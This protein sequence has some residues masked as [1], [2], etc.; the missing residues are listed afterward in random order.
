MEKKIVIARE[1]GEKF[2]TL[3]TVGYEEKKTCS[4]KA[5]MSAADKSVSLETGDRCLCQF[6]IFNNFGNFYNYERL[7]EREEFSPILVSIFKNR[8]I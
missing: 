5:V 8:R 7:H 2:L 3:C 6:C 1:R 4:Q